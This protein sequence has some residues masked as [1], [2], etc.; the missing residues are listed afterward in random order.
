M[1]RYDYIKI[2]TMLTVAVYGGSNNPP[3]YDYKKEVT[4]KRMDKYIARGFNI[5]LHPKHEEMYETIN[6][7]FCNDVHPRRLIKYVDNGTIDLSKYDYI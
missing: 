1:L 4:L 7:L 6:E 5:Q 2:N 3:N